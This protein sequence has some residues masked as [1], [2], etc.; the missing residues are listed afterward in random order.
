MRQ[1]GCDISSEA[2]G[3]PEA[4]YTPPSEALERIEIIRG[5][6]SLQFGPQL[7]GVVNYVTKKSLGNKPFSVESSQTVGSFGMFNSYNAIGGE[8][9][10]WSYYGFLHYRTANGWRE[11]SYYKT[12]TAY[13][14]VS[15]AF[16]QRWNLRLDYTSMNNL[17]QQAGGL[18]DEQF[19]SNPTVSYRSRN[20]MSTPWSLASASLNFDSRKYWVATMKLFSTIGER[21]SVGFVM[22]LSIEDTLNSSLGSY[23][24]RQVDRDAYMNFG[25]ELRMMY[26]YRMFHQRQTLSFG[27]RLYHGNTHRMQQGIGTVGSDYSLALTDSISGKLWGRDMDL[28]TKNASVYVENLIQVGE[29]LSITPGMRAEYI[30][31]GA[32]GYI[33]PATSAGRISAERN[34]LFV[35][36]GL[37]LQFSTSKNTNI[38]ANVSQGYRPATFSEQL[39]SGTT[40]VVDPNLKDARGLNV[41]LGFRGTFLECMRFDVGLFALNYENRI[42]AIAMDGAPYKTNIGTSLSKGIE[43]FVELDVLQLITK[44]KRFGSLQA[45]VN[46]TFIDARYTSWNN[47][48]IAN[49]P[50]LSIQ[51][52]RVENAPRHTL[53]TGVSY[54]YKSVGLHMQFNYIDEVFTDAANTEVPNAAA[55]IGKIPAY[56]VADAS[57]HCKVNASYSAKIG[58]NN[59]TNA[60][61][62]TRRSAGYPGPGILPGNGRTFYLTLS[63]KL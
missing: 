49:D 27:T 60:L 48:A 52:K 39:P 56:C 31:T 44:E 18:T 45:F 55:T 41:D 34:R 21:N 7:G 11:N 30:F 57:I 4:Y 50:S 59:L 29:R 62:A 36:L 47:P 13:F 32:S 38:Y 51:G 40:E 15:Y 22:P 25:A 12:R 14:T 28:R 23:N 6:G 9:K 24:P 63:I 2:F 10:K 61:Y 5:A 16:S 54:V 1:N 35:L 43:S 8:Y 26:T 20:W 46:Y 17:N 42:G 58:V 33:N 37:G 53:R 3:Y 19:M